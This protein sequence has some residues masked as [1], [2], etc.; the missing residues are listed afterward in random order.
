MMG[1]LVLAALATLLMVTV[2]GA[3]P[4]VTIYSFQDSSCGKWS[5]LGHD[6]SSARDTVAVWTRGFISAYNWFN[7]TNQVR[8]DLSNETIAAY[9]DKYCGDNPLQRLPQAVM[10][11]ICDA[12]EGAANPFAFCGPNAN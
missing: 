12:H 6:G 9:I 4:I 7:E 3:D 10:Q 5:L 11:L 8:R 1:Q 2:V